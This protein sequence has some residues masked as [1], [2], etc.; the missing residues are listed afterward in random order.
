LRNRARNFAFNVV[1]ISV[2]VERS[3]D[4]RTDLFFVAVA[5]KNRL[6]GSAPHFNVQSANDVTS[7]TNTRLP[8]M[9]GWAQVELSATVY[10]FTGSNPV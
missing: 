9:A 4:R 3:S 1:N 6:P 8:E 10:R 7:L 2:S 5:A